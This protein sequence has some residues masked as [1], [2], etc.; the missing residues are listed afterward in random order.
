MKSPQL[1]REHCVLAFPI[2]SKLNV[3]PVQN[4]LRTQQVSNSLARYQRQYNFVIHYSQ[5]KITKYFGQI[6]MRCN[7][8]KISSSHLGLIVWVESINPSAWYQLCETPT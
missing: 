8:M 6:V 1:H 2:I 7:P 4:I 3:F 5:K